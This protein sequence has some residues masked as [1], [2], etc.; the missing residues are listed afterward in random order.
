MK[1]E[2]LPAPNRPEIDVYEL[3]LGIVANAAAVQTERRIAQ[4]RR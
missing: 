3:R 4:L 1:A 2:A